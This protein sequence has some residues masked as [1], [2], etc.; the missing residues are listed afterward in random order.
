MTYTERYEQLQAKQLNE[1]EVLCHCCGSC[2]G[3]NDNDPCEHLMEVHK[4]KF[5]CDIYENRFGMHKT[6][7]GK[8]FKCVPIRDV[9]Q[10]FWAGDGNC[11]Y[12]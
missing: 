8:P 2:C 6:I 7:S 12:K 11:G 10:M 5:F 3:I 1:W 9:L 4:G